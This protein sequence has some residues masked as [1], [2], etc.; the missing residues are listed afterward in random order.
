MNNFLVTFS[1]PF[2]PVSSR[3][4]IK[5][6]GEMTIASTPFKECVT[7]VPL[8]LKVLQGQFD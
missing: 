3:R 2:V 4:S 1:R 6:R 7:T 8:Y 5:T